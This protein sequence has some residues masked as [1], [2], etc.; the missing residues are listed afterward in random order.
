MPVIQRR[1]DDKGWNLAWDDGA[2][3]LEVEL[4]DN[5][6]AGWFW[7]DR[8]SGQTAGSPDEDEIGFSE[9]FKKHAAWFSG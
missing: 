1:A 4:M 5:G 7:K 9:E 3:L 6:R 8:G 2:C